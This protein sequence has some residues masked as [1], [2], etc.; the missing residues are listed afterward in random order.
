MQTVFDMVRRASARAPDAIAIVD[1]RRQIEISYSQLLRQVERV[2]AGLVERG[3]H[4]GSRVAVALPN[5]VEA[6]IL[7]LALHRAG[8]VPALMNP[9]LKPQEIRD[10]IEFGEMHGAVLCPALA[11]A[12]PMREI[13]GLFLRVETEGQRDGL[14][15]LESDGPLPAFRPGP[16]ETAFV[17][18][19]SGTTGM[20]KGVVLS[21][22]TAESRA[23]FMVTQ[24]GYRFGAHNRVIGLMP[25]YHVIGFFAVFVLA[26]ALNGRYYVVR[27][28]KPAETAELIE[29]HRITGL[30]GTPTH[31][32]ALIGSI[33]AT[34]RDLSSLETVTF[35]GATMPD[36]VLDR[37]N[38]HLPGRKTNIYGTTEAMNSLFAEDPREGARLRP[39]FYSEVRVVPIG[40]SPQHALPPGEEGEL[41]VAADADATFTEYLNQPDATRKK[42]HD[43]WYRTSDVAVMHAN[44][45][46]EIRGRLDD[47]IISGGENIHPSEVERVLRRHPSVREAVVLGVPD[48]RW[49]QRVLACIVAHEARPTANELDEFCIASELASFKRPRAYA[50]LDEIPRNAMNKVL[51]KALAQVAQ[52]SMVALPK[53]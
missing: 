51:V 7:L 52:A 38:A 40:G 1:P 15:S 11:D 33:L 35:A 12:P 18:Y 42:L 6:C 8:A 43:G 45:D 13:N 39:G 17:F 2:A 29:A 19:T 37:V 22:R 47:M 34:P 5:S 26:L 49:G 14:G 44:G 9:R 27:D 36:P 31:L 28:F 30:F 53:T 32:D 24:S 46:V 4:P 23:L 16:E 48:E 25:L 21:Q 20:P 3:V 10:L 50:F 41:V